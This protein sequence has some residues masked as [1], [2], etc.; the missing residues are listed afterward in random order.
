MC[1]DCYLA[2]ARNSPKSRSRGARTDVGSVSPSADTPACD[3]SQRRRQ[4]SGAEKK[5]SVQQIPSLVRPNSGKR[6]VLLIFQKA[7]RARPPPPCP[8]SE[9]ERSASTCSRLCDRNGTYASLPSFRHAAATVSEAGHGYWNMYSDAA[10][11]CSE[12][13]RRPRR[14]LR[15][16]LSEGWPPPSSAVSNADRCVRTTADEQNRLQ[17]CHLHWMSV[18][19]RASTNVVLIDDT[20]CAAKDALT[21]HHSV[22][23]FAMARQ[24]VWPPALQCP[25]RHVVLPEPRRHNG[26]RWESSRGNPGAKRET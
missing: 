16:R 7:R 8:Q 3:P 2:L 9:R 6:V 12:G 17:L 25:T 15:R 20:T 4:N 13:P 11:P 22:W 14:P 10:R 26:R 23:S 5:R 21:W 18:A 24:S 1:A 19:L